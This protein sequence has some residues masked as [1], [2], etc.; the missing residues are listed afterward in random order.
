MH[1]QHTKPL[2]VVSGMIV[3]QCAMQCFGLA[4]HN[5]V[6]CYTFKLTSFPLSLIFSHPI[7]T[8]QGG[9]VILHSTC[10]SYQMRSST[11][12]KKRVY[13]AEVWPQCKLSAPFLMQFLNGINI[14]IDKIAECDPV[15]TK[16][17]HAHSHVNQE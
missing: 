14:L 2:W 15:F 9:F 7:D 3:G 17:S 16:S 11:M 1:K 5:L 10:R 8:S 12:F 6:S 4:A 13:E